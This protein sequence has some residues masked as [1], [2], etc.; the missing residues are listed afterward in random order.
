M[1]KRVGWPVLRLTVAVGLLGFAFLTPQKAS[2]CYW[3]CWDST[4]LEIHGEGDCY[5]G[6]PKTCLSCLLYCFRPV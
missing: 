6:A 3:E 5:P 4:Y 1:G 2:A